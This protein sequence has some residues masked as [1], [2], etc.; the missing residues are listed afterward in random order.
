VTNKVTG[1]TLTAEDVYADWVVANFLNDNSIAQG[2]YSY[3]GYT[4]KVPTP[5]DSIIDCPTG[6]LSIYVH[7][8]GTR[9]IE[10]ACRGNVTIDFNGSE[11][12][13]LV[14]TLPHSGRYTMWS[15]REDDSD[16][17][18]TR[19]F[20]LRSVKSPF[21]NYWVWWKIES[22][23]DYA[24]VEVS[25]DDGR[26]WKIIPTPSGTDANPV[27]SNLGWG[28]TGCSGGGETGKN[29]SAQW[30][31]EEVDLSAYAGQII[32]VRF[33][34][35]TDAVLSYASMML[36]DITVPELNYTC[37]FEQDSCDWESNGFARG[38]NVLPQMFIVQLIYQS[39][40]QTTVERLPLDPKSQGSRSLNLKDQ[41]VAI[42][43]VSGKTPFTTEEASFNLEIK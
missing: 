2:Q 15:S 4:E 32:Q 42:L 33:E 41:D 9:Y 30:V 29:C 21:L 36:D 35:I 31:N 18:L 16:T 22:D 1:E 26:T 24:Y 12:V 39:G 38:D 20:D 3:N 40:S 11:H 37:S 25:I 19:E 34:Y 17:T 6:L 5:T 28:Y 7:Q 10:L 14:L 8:F 27:G 43:V 23:F 13:S